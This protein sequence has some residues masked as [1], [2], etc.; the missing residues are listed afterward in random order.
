MGFVGLLATIIT[1][2]CLACGLFFNLMVIGSCEFLQGGSGTEDPYRFGVWKYSV[3]DTGSDFDTGGECMNLSDLFD[4]QELDWKFRT[5]QVC[6]IIAPCGGVMLLLLVLL[7][8]CC[9]PVPFLG[10]LLTL[11]YILANVG[12]S[13][14]WLVKTNDVCGT[15]VGGCEWGDGAIWLLISQIAYAIGAISYRYLPDPK[16]RQVERQQGRD[17]K[18]NDANMAAATG[19]NEDLARQLKEQ[20]TENETLQNQLKGLEE[21]NAKLKKSSKSAPGTFEAVE[22]ENENLKKQLDSKQQ[23]LDKTLNDLNAKVQEA[24]DQNEKTKKALAAATAATG[25]AA[26][27]EAVEIKKLKEENED[28]QKQ[29]DNQKQETDQR[30]SDLNSKLTEAQ[31]EHEKTKKTL[32]AATAAT[33]TAATA[34]ALEIKKLKEANN[35]IQKQLESHQHEAEQTASDLNSKLHESQD[36]HEKTKKVLAAATA[37]TATAATAEAVEIKKLKEKNDNLQKELDSKQQEADQIVKDLNVQLKE[38][39]DEHE[40]TKKELSERETENEAFKGQIADGM[41]TTETE[42]DSLNNKNQ[43]LEEENDKTKKAL[44]AATAATATAAA[45]EALEIKKLQ[46]EIEN[47][48]EQLEG[49]Q[50]KYNQTVSDLN[51]KLQASRDENEALKGHMADDMATTESATDSLNKKIQEIEE[52]NDQTKKALGVATAAT[53]TAATAEALEIKKLKEKLE[54]DEETIEKLKKEIEGGAGEASEINNLKDKNAMLQKRIKDQ[55]QDLELPESEHLEMAK[56]LETEKEKIRQAS[57]RDDSAASASAPRDAELPTEAGIEVRPDDDIDDKK[58]LNGGTME[59]Q[60]LRRENVRLKDDLDKTKADYTNKLKVLEETEIAIRQDLAAKIDVLHEKN[61]KR[62][63]ALVA[64]NATKSA[65]NTR[66][67]ELRKEKEGL[68]SKVQELEDEVSKQAVQIAK[69][70]LNAVH[71]EQERNVVSPPSESGEAEF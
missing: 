10:K 50:Q 70:T 62:K 15:L 44:C 21:E 39:Q 38:N 59:L 26:A 31:N 48:Q 18:D 25:T 51:S 2:A 14:V 69:A 12:T 66:M 42:T 20:T 53:A 71:F 17:G 49:Q 24:Q 65:E 67:R 19:D 41:S 9:C 28:L 16:V 35:D 45:A 37:A 36:E 7:S 68:K 54:E 22:E 4:K 11:G 52:E 56:E 60:E 57:A 64:A 63:A 5:A 34:E 6:S 27:V 47:L 23:E 46:D 43:E 13:L 8:Q 32:A 29:L 1:L 30:A 40:K 61:E 58:L 55:H 3:D 33:S